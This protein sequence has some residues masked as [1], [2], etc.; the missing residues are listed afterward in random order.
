MLKWK[1]KA[2]SAYLRKSM[3][4]ISLPSCDSGFPPSNTEL[5]K[6]EENNYLVP[7]FLPYLMIFLSRALQRL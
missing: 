1:S 3:S 4:T 7:P 2:D 6:I 5:A